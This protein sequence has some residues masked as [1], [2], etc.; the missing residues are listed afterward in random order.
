MDCQDIYQDEIN[1]SIKYI[2][3]RKK[4]HL[5]FYDYGQ[6][7]DYFSETRLF[8]F[9]GPTYR[10]YE[11][12]LREV[13]DETNRMHVRILLK[14]FQKYAIETEQPVW[15]FSYSS[16][17]RTDQKEAPYSFSIID[18]GR[19]IGFR[20][21][22]IERNGIDD[23]VAR[24]GLDKLVVIFLE[25]NQQS[26]Q[27]LSEFA[28]EN[29]Q[30]LRY[31]VLQTIF[32]RYFDKKA[33][34]T[35][36]KLIQE[37][38]RE[39]KKIM[40]FTAVPF[41]SSAGYFDFKQ[42][43][44]ELLKHYD[45]QN[46][47]FSISDHN[48]KELQEYLYVEKYVLDAEE[49][50]LLNDNFFEKGRYAALIGKKDFA[51]GFLT[52]EWLYCI[53]NGKEHFD[54]TSIISGYLKSI[55]QLLLSI[56]LTASRSPGRYRGVAFKYKRRMKKK[57]APV[58]D[59][60]KKIY[61]YELNESNAEYND[62]SMAGLTMF[63]KENP[64]LFLNPKLGEYT[65]D[66]LACYRIEDR[67]G[68]FHKDNLNKWDE[69]ERIRR[70]TFLLYYLL[71]GNLSLPDAE[72]KRLTDDGREPFNIIGEKVEDFSRY[73]PYLY[74]DYGADGVVE[75]FYNFKHKDTEEDKATGE[76]IYHSLSFLNLPSFDTEMLELLDLNPAL[77]KKYEILVTRE[78]YPEKIYIFERKNGKKMEI[79]L[80]EMMNE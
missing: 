33:Y 69:V 47:Q 44:A 80:M 77:V 34:K 17:V 78:S 56:L 76:T 40:A 51:E 20:L 9:T 79:N 65:E 66:L 16:F 26:I 5:R 45:Y 27:S 73:S 18:N 70:N 43:T 30:R 54:Y 49:L 2:W 29:F 75:T 15:G 60:A 39:V 32:R 22:D 7:A 67:N 38:I 1:A 35:Y 3:E 57:A 74:L 46:I 21:A 72:W 28:I 8:D 13:G 71:L 58:Y 11:H 55:E 62:D 23:I 14:L 36:K 10:E 52:S 31:C 41:L 4:L 50:Q 19:R 48:D 25:R 42:K 63:L 68:Y 53:L 24:N 6:E 64:S 37:Y 61:I 12:L 59:E